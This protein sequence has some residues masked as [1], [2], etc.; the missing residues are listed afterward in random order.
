MSEMIYCLNCDSGPAYAEASEDTGMDIC[1]KCRIG[2]ALIWAED[3]EEFDI[4]GGQQ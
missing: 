1:P 3:M 4:E 2:E